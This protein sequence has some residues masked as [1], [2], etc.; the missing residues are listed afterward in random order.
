MSAE[1][2]V[3]AYLFTTFPKNTETFLQREIVA[4]KNHGVN[5]RL[6]SI[7]GG[8]GTFRGLPVRCFNKWRLAAL[9]WKIP[10]EAWRR[11]AVLRLLLHGLCT[12]LAPSWL[13]F[14]ENMIG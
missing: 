3:I 5:L 14:W 9:L 6:Y 12:R 8:G 1:P 7:W 2:P 4:L 13:N 10:Y 11:P